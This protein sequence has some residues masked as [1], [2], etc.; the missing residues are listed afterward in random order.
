MLEAEEKEEKDKVY[1]IE[2]EETLS[3]DG[4]PLSSILWATGKSSN[5]TLEKGSDG[6]SVYKIEK[7][8]TSEQTVINYGLTKKVDYPEYVSFETDIQISEITSLERLS[9][10]MTTKGAG[11]DSRPLRFSLS[12]GSKADGSAITLCEEKWTSGSS[13]KTV[14]Q[15]EIAPKVGEWFTIKFEYRLVGGTPETKVY[16][17]GD[18]V[19]TTNGVYSAA[20]SHTPVNMTMSLVFMRQF[21]AT[22]SLD[23][24]SFHQKP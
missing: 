24:T 4:L 23:D 3:Y 9:F 13:F 14:N 11:H 18:C 1:F 15:V 6:N 20:I 17:N 10:S 19:H 8:D 21:C 2:Q 16:I 7:F 22:V 12:F 5:R